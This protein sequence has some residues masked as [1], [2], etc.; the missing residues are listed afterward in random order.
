VAEKGIHHPYVSPVADAGNPHDGVDANN[1]NADHVIG[2]TDR[3]RFGDRAAV[4]GIPVPYLQ[5]VD[6]NKPLAFDLLP[7]GVPAQENINGRTWFDVCNTDVSDAQGPVGT[8]RAACHVDRAEFGSM[9]YEEDSSLGL[10]LPVHITQ[11]RNKKIVIDG[12]G[13]VITSVRTVAPTTA[14]MPNG[15]YTVRLDEET[16]QAIFTFKTSTGGIVT[17]VVG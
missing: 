15:S 9:N 2:E 3:S 10:L 4:S 17:I 11:N 16:G 8:A 6:E 14:N 7:N 13:D 5:P 1:W 12:N